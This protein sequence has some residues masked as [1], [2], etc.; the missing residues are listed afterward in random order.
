MVDILALTGQL[1]FILKILFPFFYKTSYLNEEV[2]CAVPS[3][4]ISIPCFVQQTA[5]DDTPGNFSHIC[6]LYYKH[7]IIVIDTASATNCSITYN[8]N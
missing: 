4:S 2:N 3:P 8:H 5:H 7:I 1:L 6:G